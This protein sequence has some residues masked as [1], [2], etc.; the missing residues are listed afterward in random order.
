MFNYVTKGFID[1]LIKAGEGEEGFYAADYLDLTLGLHIDDHNIFRFFVPEPPDN[2]DPIYVLQILYERGIKS[3]TGCEVAYEL[4]CSGIVRDGNV[5]VEPG[6]KPD[7]ENV[8]VSREPLIETITFGNYSE[9]DDT[10]CILQEAFMNVCKHKPFVQKV[11]KAL[12]QKVKC[13]DTCCME[14]G[15]LLAQEV[16]NVCEDGAYM[17]DLSDVI[18]QGV[19]DRSLSWILNGLD[20]SPITN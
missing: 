11:I 6:I 15:C 3:L 4:F 10:C 1:N 16:I 19:K 7:A 13:N 5:I 17:G 9:N 18:A 2:V 14:R 20:L 12:S 8:F